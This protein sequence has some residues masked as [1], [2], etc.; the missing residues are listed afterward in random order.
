MDTNLVLFAGQMRR[1]K[2][3]SVFAGNRRLMDGIGFFSEYYCEIGTGFNQTLNGC[4]INGIQFGEII[5]IEPISNSVPDKF[6]LYQNYPNPFN[7]S[8]MIRFDIPSA[9]AGPQT[10]RLSIYDILGSEI[11]T[12]VNE[13]LNPGTYEVQWNAGNYSSGV[14]FCTIEAGH[15]KETAKMMLIR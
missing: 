9:E 6:K 13:Q 3:I 7:P 2:L 1:T 15:F 11:E 14:Y 12:L 4:I 8:T 10:V 5:G